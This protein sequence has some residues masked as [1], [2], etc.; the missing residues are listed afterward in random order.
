[1]QPV[2][3]AWYVVAL[4]DVAPQRGKAKPARCSADFTVPAA[5][6]EYARLMRKWCRHPESVEVVPV[7]CLERAG[8]L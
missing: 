7:Y 2:V 6:E 1:M 5:A 4:P 8:G 3:K